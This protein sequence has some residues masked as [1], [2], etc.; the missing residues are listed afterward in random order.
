MSQL[1]DIIRQNVDSEPRFEDLSSRLHQARTLKQLT[2][3][4]L[5]LG[6][7]VA[8][9]V[10]EDILATRAEAPEQAGVCPDCGTRLVSKGFSDRRVINTII[11]MVG[12]R[13]RL[14][15]CPRGCKIGQIAPFDE[16]L[17]VEPNEKTCEGIKELACLLAVF[18][19]Y[20]IASLLL[21]NLLGVEACPSSVWNW[22]QVYGDKAISR[23]DKELER[24]SEGGLPA[25][26]EIDDKILRLKMA[27]GADGVMLPFRPNGG[28]PEGKSEWHEV[29]IGI[30]ARLME[31]INKKG[32]KVR[33]IVRKRVVAV[34]GT[35]DDLRPRMELMAVKERMDEAE[36]VAWLSDGGPWLW[37][38]FDKV[39]AG[40]VRGVLDFYHAVQNIWKGAKACFDGRTKYAREWFAT[41]RR[42]VK[43]GKVKRVL[44]EIKEALESEYLPESARK[45]LENLIVYLETHSEH[46][47]YDKLRALGLPI[48]SGMVES[49]CKWLIQ[50]R[51]KGVGM[52]WSEAGFNKLLHLRLAWV[53]GEFDALFA[54]RSP[55]PNC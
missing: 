21:K 42:K 41:A 4:A 38:I 26:S 39:F 43:V 17:G 25:A 52:R 46:M 20:Q 37:G 19:P 23:F 11:G 28:A 31:K 36:D 34:L 14:W 53:N 22:V 45:T 16:Q 18:V 49:T 12:W 44:A 8:V 48:G 5:G 54:S 32:R 29:K 24:F 9:V 35:V 50:Q 27:M 13:R 1:L 55:S 47:C 30:F 2:L 51:F 3:A 40:R 10:V 33:V 7:F 6:L 15:R